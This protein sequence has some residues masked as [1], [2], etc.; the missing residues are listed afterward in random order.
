[1]DLRFSQQWL[2]RVVLYDIPPCSLLK[3]SW[4]FR[5]TCRFHLWDQSR[6]LLAI[7]FTPV[8]CLVYSSALK[9]EV[10]CSSEMLDD[11]QRTTQ[12]YSPEDRTHQNN[13]SRSYK[14]PVR[15]HPVGICF[16]FP[17][18][19]YTN[20]VICGICSSLIISSPSGFE[21]EYPRVLMKC[22]TDSKNVCTSSWWCW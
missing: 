4:H 8:S 11:F 12:C 6:G 22:Y 14:Y 20:S 18:K 16:R 13:V 7:C 15:G 1:L 9:M 2:W 10:T 17:P 3:V 19:G 21:Q 5:G